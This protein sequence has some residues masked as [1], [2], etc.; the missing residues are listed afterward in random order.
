MANERIVIIENPEYLARTTGTIGT[1][2]CRVCPVLPSGL[3]L[4]LPQGTNAAGTHVCFSVSSGWT[5][6]D[7]AALSAMFASATY[8]NQLPGDW[9]PTTGD[10]LL[11]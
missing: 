5:D 8:T 3:T 6:A 10:D 2:E 7:Q 1:Y 11:P 4:T 9:W